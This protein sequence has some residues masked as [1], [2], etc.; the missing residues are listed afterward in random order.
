M[1][2]NKQP[3]EMSANELVS[4]Y[5]EAV[6]ELAHHQAASSKSFLAKFQWELVLKAELLK[7]L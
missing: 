2:V 5:S 1:L 6:I 4:S 3:S 7:R